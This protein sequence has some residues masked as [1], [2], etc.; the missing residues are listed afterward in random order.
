MP[1]IHRPDRVLTWVLPLLPAGVALLLLALVVLTADRIVGGELKL[2]ASQ[3]VEQSA[4]ALAVEVSRMLAR[5]TAEVDLLGVLARTDI[6]RDAWRSQLQ[7]IKASSSAYVWIGA[8]DASGVV[9]VA[10]DGLLEGVSIA[11]R[12]VFTNGR[13]GAWFGSLHPPVALREPLRTYGLPVPT[14]LADI[15]LPIFDGEGRQRGV[16]AAHLDAH[17]FNGL[18]Q[19][20][21]GPVEGRRFLKLAIVDGDGRVMM[22][23]RPDVPEADLRSLLVGPPGQVRAVAD[24]NGDTLLLAHRPIQ[25]ADSPLRTNWQVVAAQPLNAALSPVRQLERSLVAWGGATALLIGLLGFAVSR[26]LAH[27]FSQSEKH[28]REQGEVLAAVINSASDAVISVDDKGRITLFN[29]A[30]AHIFGHAAEQMVGQPLDVLLPPSQ[31]G[32]HLSYLQRF[33]ESKSTTRPMGVGRV[34]GVRADGQLLELEASISQITVRGRRLLT[35]ILRDVT[36]RVRDE[37]ALKRY[38]S[39]LSEL[40]RRLLDQEKQTTRKLAQT[41]HDQL[42]QTL[43]AIRLS[44]D[45]LSGLVADHLS[46]RARDRERKLGGLIDQAIVEVRQALVALRP[47]LLDEAG[48]PTA[49]DNEMRARSAEAELTRLRLEVAPGAQSL[50]WPADVE[51]AAFMIAREALANALLHAQASEVVVQIDGT[52]G[53]L[54]LQV[55]DDGVGLSPEMAGGRPGHLGIVGMR[56]RAL[57]IG[58]RMEAHK[59]AGGGTLIS[60]KWGTAK[61]SNSG[62]HGVS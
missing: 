21:L 13:H 46:P 61:A 15:A 33:G 56:E 57:A 62:L 7:R 37:R 30:A 10:T 51:Y 27:P 50:R 19:E 5:R 45:A 60:L 6:R 18:I 11:T 26:R 38:Q 42:G 44:F 23:E 8:T 3:R 32:L 36:E 20:V 14:D 4:D 35:A 58:A 12:P 28:L 1:T 31:R 52:P 39:E 34:G 43:G 24:L 17:H 53:W 16:I 22:G 59:A 2:R 47:P 49:L 29:P 9:E 41:L 55:S 54:S 40:A 48:L 25:P